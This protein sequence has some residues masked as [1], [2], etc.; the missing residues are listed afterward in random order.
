M[1]DGLVALSKHTPA[2]RGDRTLLDALAPFCF[3]LAEGKTLHDAARAAWD[4]ANSTKGMLPTLGRA[5]YMRN[6][7]LAGELPPD[8]G[9]WGVAAIVEGFCEGFYGVSP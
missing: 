7:G 9:A 5:A 1:N 3:T 2:Q 8:P 4:G 6:T